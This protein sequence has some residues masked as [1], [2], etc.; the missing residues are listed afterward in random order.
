[1]AVRHSYS[2]TMCSAV[3][4]GAAICRCPE[5]LPACEGCVQ[6]HAPD[7]LEREVR[8]LKAALCPCLLGHLHAGQQRPDL[9]KQIYAP[10]PCHLHM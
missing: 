1:M 5:H 9:A 3:L 8:Q 2:S 10:L 6:D 4:L 7:L